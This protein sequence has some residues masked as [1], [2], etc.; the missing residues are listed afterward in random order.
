M[1]SARI[2]LCGRLVVELDRRRIEADLPGRQ[3][4]LLFAYLVVNRLRAMSREELAEALWPGGQ[5][6]GLSPLLSKLRRFLAIEG[7][8]EIRIAL[9]SDAW[10]D[11]EAAA[12]A[13]HRAE[14]ALARGD[15]FGAYGPARVTQHI[16]MR[17]FFAA[18][19]PPWTTD[20]QQRL[21][22]MHTRSLE[23]LA[24]ACLHIGGAELATGER[25]AR[26]LV[27]L[28]PY[29]ESGYRMLMDILEARGNRADAL[30]LY[31][32]LRTLL[33]HELGVTP[34]E[35]TR[36]IHRRLLN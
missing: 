12:D 17:A 28:E 5:D 11:L 34:S 21:D 26:R 10:V 24:P 30:R 16:A 25:A 6:A 31:E 23:L 18:D 22:I 2:Q 33:Q 13:L 29:R 7:R 36:E 9:P 4:R 15:W 19:G 35:E 3:G 14:S 27:S 8:G 32:Q 1:A 20:V